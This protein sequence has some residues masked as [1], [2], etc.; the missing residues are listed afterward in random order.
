[1]KRLSLETKVLHAAVKV[2]KNKVGFQVEG[3]L[4]EVGWED[5]QK[6]WALTANHGYWI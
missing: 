2:S 3:G 1:M 5:L 4:I 6:S